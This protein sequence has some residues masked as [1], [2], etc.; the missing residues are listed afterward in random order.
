MTTKAIVLSF[1]LVGCHSERKKELQNENKMVSVILP[2]YGKIY[3]KNISKALFWQMKD[4]YNGVFV[5]SLSKTFSAQ[6]Y[7]LNNGEGIIERNGYFTHYRKFDDLIKVLE[8]FDQLSRAREIL[9][10]RNRYGRSFSDSTKVLIKE[11]LDQL[12]IQRTGIDEGLLREVDKEIGR[13]NDIED[14]CD[15]YFLNL[16]ALVGEVLIKEKECAWKLELSDDGETWNCHLLFKGEKIIFV[17]FLYEDLFLRRTDDPL[18]TTYYSVSD[19][20]EL[21]R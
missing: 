14:F 1:L 6:I 7:K 11:L 3:R 16:V 15:E 20:I 9:Y 8:N 2:G 18:I 13:L 10:G 19:I 4:N 21:K 12:N 17:G 5:D